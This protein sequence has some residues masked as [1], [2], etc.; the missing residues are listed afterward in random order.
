MGE[1]ANLAGSDGGAR[2]GE[3][4]VGVGLGVRRVFGQVAQVPGSNGGRKGVSGVSDSCSEYSRI[5]HHARFGRAEKKGAR[6]K[7]LAKKIFPP[8]AISKKGRT[9]WQIF[10]PR[11][12]H[13]FVWIRSHKFASDD[14]SVAKREARES[15][16]ESGENLAL[17]SLAR[18]ENGGVAAASARGLSPDVLGVHIV[19]V[20]GGGC[21]RVLL[22]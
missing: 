9:R 3:A 18:L 19:A 13:F 1:I 17:G 10:H 7:T 14:R 8:A 5:F 20:V 2:G 16:Q 11:V 12:I 6:C 4:L 15:T 22:Q 21:P